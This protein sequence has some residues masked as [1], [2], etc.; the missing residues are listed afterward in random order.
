MI[1]SE[2]CQVLETFDMSSAPSC[3]TSS[4]LG[5]AMA[6]AMS[7]VQRALLKS[8]NF[9]ARRF[10][11]TLSQVLK[12]FSFFAV[13]D[14]QKREAI[15]N[16]NL[17]KLEKALNDDKTDAW[18]DYETALV[19]RDLAVI[20]KH[21][22]ADPLCQVLL[23]LIKILMFAD[24]L[25]RSMTRV[26][27]I[28]TDE[29]QERLDA[30]DDDAYLAKLL[31]KAEVAEKKCPANDPDRNLLDDESVSTPPTVPLPFNQPSRVVGVARQPT[32]KLDEDDE[33]SVELVTPLKRMEA[34][35]EPPEHRAR[36]KKSRLHGRE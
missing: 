32:E 10:K 19:V 23:Q 16:I 13:E 2:Y 36:I 24:H 21:D 12:S 35:C 5:Q 4:A 17:D 33:E 9:R 30:I 28:N 20:I 27:K 11:K 3:S 25:P 15:D 22:P 14:V 26:W 7:G 31:V 8:V 34:M 1:C 18:I 29:Y 6:S